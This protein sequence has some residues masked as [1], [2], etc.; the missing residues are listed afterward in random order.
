[1]ITPLPIPPGFAGQSSQK[2]EIFSKSRGSAALVA[3]SAFAQGSGETRRRGRPQRPDARLSLPAM[4]EFTQI[5]FNAAVLVMVVA[6][7]MSLKVWVGGRHAICA[8]RANTAAGRHERKLA[9]SEVDQGKPAFGAGL[10][11]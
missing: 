4:T 6:L 7:V 8:E 3:A 2:N 1:M 5:T 11:A 10:P 9:L